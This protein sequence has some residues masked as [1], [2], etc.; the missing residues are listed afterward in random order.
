MKPYNIPKY[1]GLE[2]MPKDKNDYKYG[3][4]FGT[5]KDILRKFSRELPK[6]M[7]IPYQGNVPACVNACFTFVNQ[8]KSRVNDGNDVNLSF[9][10]LHAETGP[11]GEGR[12]LRVP[13]AYLKTNGQPQEKYCPDDVSL[14]QEEF[15]N[16]ALTPEGIEDSLKRKIGVYSF[17]N[18]GDLNELCSAIMREPIVG[19]LGGTNEDWRKPFNEVVKQTMQPKWYH[20]V[21]FWDYDLDEGWIGIYNWWNDGYRRISIDYKLTGSISFEDLPDGDND[22]MFKVLKTI[23]RQDHWLIVGDTR[24]RIPDSDTFH[25]FKGQ[26]GIIDDPIVVLREELKRYTVGEMLPSVLLTRN[27]AEIASNIF[28][29]E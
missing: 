19:S 21:C 28:K 10:K 2:K 13:A 3:A 26:L 15:M 8:Y 1:P 17:V 16:V 20:S 29:E 4:I 18:D 22:T 25:Y 14:P 24:R 5:E 11:Y 23:D 12:Y 9:R 6:G 7:N 27:M